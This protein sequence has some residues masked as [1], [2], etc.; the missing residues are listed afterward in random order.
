M[1]KQTR[2]LCREKNASFKIRRE[3]YN[4]VSTTGRD[5]THQALNPSNECEWCDLYDASSKASGTWTSRP[6][7]ACDDK[8]QCTKKDTCS[9][10]KCVGE[11]YS[12]QSSYPVS[13]CVRTS[14]CV[15]DGTCRDVMRS[16]GTIC[17]AA[18]DGCDKPER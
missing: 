16:A 3:K 6:A 10:G 15:G 5:Y 1:W 17:R 9:A 7:V 2:S 4:L 12:C 14:Q 18:A 13:S 11:A 8:N